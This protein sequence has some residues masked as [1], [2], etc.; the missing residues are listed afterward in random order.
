[1]AKNIIYEPGYN[2]AVVVTDPATP[3]S[4]DPVRFGAL[5]GIALLD[6]GDGGAGATETV[7]NFGPFVADIPVVA[8]AGAIAVGD[9][10]FYDDAIDGVNNDSTNGYFY[11]FALEAIGNGLT[12]T[13]N[14]F[15]VPSPGAGTLGAGTV[16]AANLAANAV[17]AAKIAA[18]IIE[19]TK[20]EKSANAD[21]TPCVPTL[22]RIDIAGGA[23]GNTDVVLDIK[24][25][26]IDAWAV[27][28]G[29]AGEANDT[30][31]VFN[32]AN[33]ITDAMAWSGADKAIVRAAS[34]DDANH[35][36]A[37]AGTLRVTTT[38][39]DA[40]GDVGAGIVYVLTVP[41]A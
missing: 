34:I 12:D 11:G 17:T 10:L 19:G 27:H 32:G 3:A 35:E 23:A 9:A 28:T 16:G 21:T 38:D 37:A 31:Q 14:V 24:E 4:G 15:H 8:E 18:A 29:G 36:I 40:G 1:M 22:H 26:V 41:V 5:T 7:C 13:I 33:A 2:Q 20:I 30:I 25:R 39:D 6:E